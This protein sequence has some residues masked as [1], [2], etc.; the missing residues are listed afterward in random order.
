[1]KSRSIVIHGHFYQPPRE[2]PWLEELEREASAAPF[3]DWNERIEQECYRA[4]VAARTYDADGRIRGILNT[5]ER[6]SFDYGP[7]LLEW[8]EREAPGTYASVLAADR[9]SRARS[10]GGHGNAI[11]SPYHHII[12]PLSP[13]REKVTEVRWGIADF[14]RRFGREP[15]GFWLPETAVDDE[16]LDVV[17]SEG[18]RYTIVAPHQVKGAPHGGRA[19]RYRTRA[20]HEIALF[21]YDGGISHDVAFGPLLRDSRQ[22]LARLTAADPAIEVLSLATDGE[23]FGH[24]HRFGEIAL[25]WLLTE[26][27][28]HPGYAVENFSAALERYPATKDVQLVEPSS[29]SCVHGIERWRSDCGCRIAP[30]RPTQQAW[31]APLRQGLDSLAAE[32]HAQFE[33]EGARLFRDCWAAREAYGTVVASAPDAIAGFVATQLEGTLDAR[34]T[35]RARE[36]LEME[37]N[38]L[39]MFTSCGWFF[40][41]LAGLEPLQVLRYAARA[42]ELAG[43]DAAPGLEAGLLRHLADAQSNDPDAGTGD[44]VYRE[45]IKPRIAPVLRIA[46]GSVAAARLAPA[47]PSAATRCYDVRDQDGTVHVLHCRT[48]RE[49]LCH[50]EGPSEATIRLTLR[51]ALANGGPPSTLGLSQLPERARNAVK[52]ALRRALVERRLPADLREGV[53]E[54]RIDLPNATARAL[55]HAVAA[56]AA[57]QSVAAVEAVIDLADLLEL[58]GE[59]VPFDAQTRLYHVRSSLGPELG[60]RLDAAAWRLGFAKHLGG[61]D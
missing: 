45:R 54:G 10:P 18:I 12:L 15:V 51:A 2:D 20:G 49:A 40:D 26:I 48:G 41:D 14:R 27:E 56:L 4:V 25:A 21:A 29:W 58:E 52:A 37:R 42:I 30:Q 53:D 61:D 46:A 50:V 36:L 32:L 5:L 43:P 19:G 16:T 35:V 39:R 59:S 24:H 38:T 23:T 22:W 28:R 55:E 3:H 33:R 44:R 9:A 57:D 8:M 60:G 6:I 34:Q 47:D 7:T 17:A 1:M 11:A 13:R 31:R